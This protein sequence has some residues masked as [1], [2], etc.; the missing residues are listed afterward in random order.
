MYRTVAFM[1]KAELTA[2]E[3]V[4]FDLIQDAAEAGR[5]CPGNK[6]FAAIFGTVDF[7]GFSRILRALERKG[8]IAVEAR[9]RLPRVVTLLASGRKTYDGRETRAAQRRPSLPPARSERPAPADAPRPFNIRPGFEAP[10]ALTCQFIDGDAASEPGR[11]GTPVYRR[12]LCEDHFSVCYRRANRAD[13]EALRREI[14]YAM[15]GGRDM[16]GIVA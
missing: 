9:G 1:S 10:V 4:V 15:G 2:K 14:E 13:D 11:C 6:L 3:N 5:P 12:S 7:A 16:Y 8:L